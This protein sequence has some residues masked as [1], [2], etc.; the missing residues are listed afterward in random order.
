MSKKVKFSNNDSA[1]DFARKIG[2]RVDIAVGKSKNCYEVK[3]SNASWSKDNP[4][5]IKP[6]K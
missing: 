4:Y 5:G 1:H 2:G 3:T 6:N